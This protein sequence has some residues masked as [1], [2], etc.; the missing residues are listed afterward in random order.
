MKSDERQSGHL[1]YYLIYININPMQKKLLFKA[2]PGDIFVFSLFSADYYRVN[3]IRLLE[4]IQF[5]QV[6]A[7]CLWRCRRSEEQPVT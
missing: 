4:W 7:A 1:G 2:T 6:Q 5:Q 3:L